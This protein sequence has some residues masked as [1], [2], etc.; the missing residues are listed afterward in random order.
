MLKEIL[1]DRPE[2][3]S[4]AEE[5]LKASLRQNKSALTALQHEV[6]EAGIPVLVLLEGWG[7]AGKGGMMA[8]IL[9]CLDPR[10]FKSYSTTPPTF[11]ESRRP[12]LWRHWC[13]IPEKGR[14][15]IMDRSW[16]PE[17]SLSRLEGELTHA[18]A[19]YRMERVN[20]FERQLA[21][22]GVLLFKFFLHISQ[23]EQKKRLKKLQK[24][25]ETAW[26]VTKQDWKRNEEYDKYQKIF[27][28]MLE[29]TDTVQAPWHLI[30]ASNQ[31]RA[32][33]EV[34]SILV[35]GIRS[36]LEKK[37]EKRPADTMPLLVPEGFSLHPQ[38]ALSEISL[39]KKAD[40]ASYSTQLKQAQKKLQ[41]LHNL[42]YLNKI[43]VIAVYEGWDAAGK[44]GNIR[45]LVKALDPRGYEVVP[46][47]APSRAELNH[48][49]L[50]RFWK[51]V[52]K[53]G[54]IAIFDR[55][56]YGRV[57][58]E[59]IEG[60]CTEVEWK[61]AYQEINEFEQELTDWG[62]ILLKFWLHIDKD[63]Q[64]RRFDDRQ[65]TPEKRWKITDEDWRNREKWDQ[66]EEAVNDMLRL[67]STNFAPWTIVESQDKKY[68][69]LK[70]LDT[71]ISRIEKHLDRTDE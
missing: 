1:K 8:D 40:P 29:K 58:V 34:F 17:L 62:A 30:D 65:N 36:A 33:A 61:R 26:R 20:I 16:Y 53:E 70:V 38:P 22:D 57:M 60:F 13:R 55:S 32:Q 25:P 47:A 67:T 41:K 5:T 37:L 68:G 31:D 51:E 11:E 14:F 35:D 48:H 4:E 49:Y 52:P 56:W 45:R 42:L 3:E 59:R 44:G 10:N 64:L 19:L 15:V 24:S 18:Q 69:R 21:D 43:P 27:D 12:F 50:W 39:D 23:K 9:L 71:F 46:I 28:E 66:Y 6:R 7:A 63:E 2:L 54:H